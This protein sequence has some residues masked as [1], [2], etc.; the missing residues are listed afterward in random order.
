MPSADKP[1]VYLILGASGSGRREVLV[2]LIKELGDAARPAVML[3]EGETETALDAQ[4]ANVSRW[5]FAD[6]LI[7]GRLPENVTPVFFVADGR[8]NPVEQI[9]P[10]KPW[11]DAQGGEL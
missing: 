3:A 6:D 5:T 9:E 4:L 1:L 10:F 2:D 8:R 11:L 7:V